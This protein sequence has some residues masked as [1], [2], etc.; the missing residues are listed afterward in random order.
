M[1]TN[2]FLFSF[3]FL[4]YLYFSVFQSFVAVQV[5]LCLSVMVLTVLPV[6]SK[7]SQNGTLTMEW[8]CFSVRIP[9]RV[10]SIEQMSRLFD[11]WVL[12]QMQGKFCFEIVVQRPYW[13][14]RLWWSLRKMRGAEKPSSSL[15]IF[16]RW[17]LDDFSTFGLCPAAYIS[18]C[19]LF[20]CNSFSGCRW[21]RRHC[22]ILPTTLL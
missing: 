12:H 3:S 8:A 19:L 17:W 5:N 18:C 2:S 14:Q 7:Q 22:C 4:L 10:W 21:Y 16:G 15:Q 11:Q 20:I 6:K 9:Y 13:L 1:R